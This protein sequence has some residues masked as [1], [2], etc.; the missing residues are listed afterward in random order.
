MTDQTNECDRLCCFPTQLHVFGKVF[1]HLP[2]TSCQR[3]FIPNKLVEVQK[4]KVLG[5]W[6]HAPGA[7]GLGLVHAAHS[8]DHRSA[9]HG[10]PTFEPD[11]IL[12]PEDRAGDVHPLGTTAGKTR[13]GAL[14]LKYF[15]SET[16]GSVVRLPAAV[17]PDAKVYETGV[18]PAVICCRDELCQ[19]FGYRNR[20]S[21]FFVVAMG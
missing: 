1:Y 15:G 16:F 3:G 20:V 9:T 7:P 5:L 18:K 14:A 6:T 17:C 11:R 21:P 10:W 12:G 8:S 13:T 19:A 2:E 4:P